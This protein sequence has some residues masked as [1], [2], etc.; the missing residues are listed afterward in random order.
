MQANVLSVEV[1]LDMCPVADAHLQ[2]KACPTSVAGNWYR[3]ILR[4][5]QTATCLDTAGVDGQ[6]EASMA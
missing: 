1:L 4:C 2:L 5:Q 6:V 3:A